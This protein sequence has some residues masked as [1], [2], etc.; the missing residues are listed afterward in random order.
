MFSITSSLFAVLVCVGLTLPTR[1]DGGGTNSVK[2]VQSPT[3]PILQETFA[4]KNIGIKEVKGRER[5]ETQV[6]Q[7]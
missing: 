4:H 3:P 7:G 2:S 5:T 1:A 6:G